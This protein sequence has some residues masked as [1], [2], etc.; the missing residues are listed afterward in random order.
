MRQ[1]DLLEADPARLADDLDRVRDEMS[2]LKARADALRE[3]LIAARPNGPVVGTAYRATVRQAVTRRFDR[4]LLPAHIRE[5][6]RHFRR[7]PSQT[8]VSRPLG[9]EDVEEEEIVLIEPF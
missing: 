6:P 1:T 2:I 7:I 4:A 3:A 8:V 9:P 5:D